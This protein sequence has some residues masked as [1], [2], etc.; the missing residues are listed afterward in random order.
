LHAAWKTDAAL[1]DRWLDF[2]LRS[3]GEV[4]A[5]ITRA[6]RK[7]SPRTK[8]GIQ[9]AFSYEKLTIALSRAIQKAMDGEKTCVRLGGGAYYDASPYDQIA[10]SWRMVEARSRLGL[11]DVV[12]NWC[13]EI[14]TYP[15]AY[16]SR[17]VRSIAL[18]AF[19]SIGWGF[20]SASLFVM[21]RR[22]ETDDF[23]SRYLLRPLCS[24]TKFL[25]GYQEA[26]RG[27][28]PAG[29]TCPIE[30]DDTRHL[31]GVPILPGLGV[32]W[33]EINSELQ[34]FPHLG[35]V[36]GDIRTDRMTDYR[37]TPSA[38]MQAIREGVSGSAPLGVLLVVGGWMVGIKTK[39]LQ[40]KRN[41]S[42][43]S[44]V[45]RARCVKIWSN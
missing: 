2:T 31:T 1:R 8:A 9:T 12:D 36:W 19:S 3:L 43:V 16:G 32:S 7:V 22:S 5:V 10:K 27:T 40:L 29:F 15:R 44:C 30:S 35:P 33:G 13:T 34:V 24:V 17:S 23:Y 11:E 25:N 4:A 6:F 14:E 18:E 21:D 38:K 42:P 37:K 45:L 28:V 39:Q 20:D 26:N 41:R